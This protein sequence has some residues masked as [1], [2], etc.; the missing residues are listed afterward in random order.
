MNTWKLRR[1]IYQCATCGC[2]REVYGP[3][4]RYVGHCLNCKMLRRRE[5]DRDRRALLLADA[6]LLVTS[7]TGCWIWLGQRVNRGY[8]PYGRYFDAFKGAVPFPTD[9]DR[10]AGQVNR[11]HRDHLCKVRA[12]VN[13]YHLQLVKAEINHRRRRNKK[14]PE[15]NLF[16]VFGALSV[17]VKPWRVARARQQLRKLEEVA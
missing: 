5:H 2:E 14:R 10:E 9:E 6:R 1:A 16:D 8:G 7:D 3:Q 15:A 11:D 17:H 4:G 12:C 13:P